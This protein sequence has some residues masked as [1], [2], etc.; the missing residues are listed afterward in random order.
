MAEYL[1]TQTRELIVEAENATEAR[2]IAEDVYHVRPGFDKKLYKSIR[3]NNLRVEK[4]R[5]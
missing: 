1:A 4:R 2:K 5:N 3:V